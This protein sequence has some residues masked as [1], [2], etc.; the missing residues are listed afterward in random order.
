MTKHILS[1]STFMYG[2]QCP[3]RLYMHKFKSELRNPVDEE[4]TAVFTMGTNIGLLAQ[5]Y[6][7]GGIDV[8]P[9]D[10][11][12][13]HIS[14]AKTQELIKTG[15]KI[16]YE[17]AFNYDGILCAVDIL[18]NQKGNW[19]AYEVKNV[20]KVKPAHIK[21]AS[22]QYYVI[23][24][25][26]LP[27]KDFSIM[28]LDTSYVKRGEV[29]INKLFS[30][31]SVLDQVLNN[32]KFIEEKAE[33]LKEMLRTKKE[34]IVE[35]GDHCFDP[36][37]CDFTEHCWKNVVKEK[38]DYGK[39]S[40]DKK[41]IKEFI[42]ELQYPLYFFDFETVGHP[43]PVYDESRPYQAV[44]FQYSLHFQKTKD[45]E[46]EHVYFLGDGVN[47]PREALINQML[48]H[49]KDK[50]SI[51]VWYKPFE[52][53]KLKNL[54]RDFPKYEMQIN[55]MIDRLVDLRD[56]FRYEHYYH[57]EFE[58]STSIKSVLPVLIPELSYGD[59]EVQDGMTASTTY[60][61]LSAQPK[62]EQEKIRQ[63]L[64]DYCHLDTL[65]MVRIL[66]KIKQL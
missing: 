33:E 62:N 20:T 65:A 60:A 55:K 57:P 5:D 50:G 23:T 25:S 27:L 38:E 8:S 16:I 66:D 43:V 63:A 7:P 39:L 42:S 26:G 32:Q 6:F 64:L 3:L 53:G 28:H 61:N 52:S 17:A 35:P 46:L 12:S 2:C 10:P 19:Y 37:D 36:Y 45:A 40:I 1:K 24:K 29:E 47:D 30:Y 15:Q 4:Q 9:P 14:V 21:D 44:P 59:L 58:G 51:L 11:Y 54:M 48:E 41:A 18:I 49:V 56:P 31:T 34:P 22:L 13:Y